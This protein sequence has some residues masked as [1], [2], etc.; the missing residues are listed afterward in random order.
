MTFLLM[1]S[2]QA[3]ALEQQCSLCEERCSS[4]MLDT[5]SS[6]QSQMFPVAPLQDTAKPQSQGEGTRE[7]SRFQKGVK[8]AQVEEETKQAAAA[9]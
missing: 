3:L 2:A 5:A 7:N 4:P 9:E 1:C 6:S 8:W